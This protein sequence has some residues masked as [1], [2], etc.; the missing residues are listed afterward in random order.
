LFLF[1]SCSESPFFLFP[2][3]KHWTFYPFLRQGRHRPSFFRPFD[4]RPGSP[5]FPHDPAVISPFLMPTD[6]GQPLPFSASFQQT[7]WSFF[8]SPPSPQKPLP[9]LPFSSPLSR[10]GGGGFFFPPPNPF[11]F[12]RSLSANNVSI[13]SSSFPPPPLISS[14]HET[15]PLSA[16]GKVNCSLLAPRHPTFGLTM[17]ACRPGF[18]LFPLF[19]LSE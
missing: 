11:E 5:L 12:Y 10:L 8:P 16:E 2:S 13:T 6:H 18:S 14:T 9:D 7:K 4:G 3:R 15:A 17:T 19:F 1:F